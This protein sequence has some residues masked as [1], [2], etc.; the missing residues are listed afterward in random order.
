MGDAGLRRLERDAHSPQEAARFL[1]QAMRLGFSPERVR[2]AA[3]LGHEGA[4]LAISPDDDWP[5]IFGPD[6]IEWLAECG[7]EASVRV[8]LALGQFRGTG[9][10]AERALRAAVAWLEARTQAEAVAAADAARWAA[11]EAPLE[12]WGR[13][14]ALFYA[15]PDLG[16]ELAMLLRGEPEQDIH[17]ALTKALRAAVVPWAL[18]LDHGDADTNPRAQFPLAPFSSG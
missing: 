15:G 4:R 14:G 12:P 6:W 13:I 11:N 10:I 7:L 3:L 16:R 1:S 17:T 18:S 2:L 9:E 8:V 5:T